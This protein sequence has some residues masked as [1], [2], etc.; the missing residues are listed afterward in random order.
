MSSH[1]KQQQKRNKYLLANHSNCV[2]SFFKKEP[3]I[4]KRVT[5]KKIPVI[6]PE[7]CQAI[8]RHI[9]KVG[10]RDWMECI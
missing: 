6:C 9:L 2:V 7:L 8:C 1:E 4:F 5:K 3:E 10:Y